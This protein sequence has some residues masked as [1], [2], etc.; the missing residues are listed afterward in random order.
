[1]GRMEHHGPSA[2]E[3]HRQKIPMEDRRS[4]LREVLD[5][6]LTAVLDSETSPRRR[7]AVTRSRAQLAQSGAFDDWLLRPAKAA[8]RQRSL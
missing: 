5:E 1:M 6:R 4:A 2:T 8:P 7:V 3:P